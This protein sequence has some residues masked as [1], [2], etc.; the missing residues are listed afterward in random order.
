MGLQLDQVCAVA[1]PAI[2]AARAARLVRQRLMAMY[3]VRGV[4]GQ[5]MGLGKSIAIQG[6]QLKKTKDVTTGRKAGG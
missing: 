3:G 4:A 1:E 6:L 2:R 5:M